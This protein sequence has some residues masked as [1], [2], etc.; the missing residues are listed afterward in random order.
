M[1]VKTY[2][3]RTLNFD[4]YDHIPTVNNVLDYR[5]GCARQTVTSV[6]K[7][8]DEINELKAQNDEF[9]FLHVWCECEILVQDFDENEDLFCYYE[10]DGETDYLI[11]VENKE[12]PF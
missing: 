5:P 6:K 10:P 1:K 2:D 9:I 7:I 12:I 11:A 3:N 8:N 4:I